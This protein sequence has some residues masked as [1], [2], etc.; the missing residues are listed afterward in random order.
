ME[1]ISPLGLPPQGGEVEIE[2]EKEARKAWDQ[3][4]LHHKAA[5]LRALELPVG[6]PDFLELKKWHKLPIVVQSDLADAF[7]MGMW[8]SR[9]VV[10][11]A[12]EKAA[13]EADEPDDASA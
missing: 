1:E 2:L 8:T 12:F 10:K 13:K 6:Q 9:G 3:T 4:G 5:I 11:A 7:E